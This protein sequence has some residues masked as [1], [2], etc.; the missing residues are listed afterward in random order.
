VAS[1]VASQPAHVQPRASVPIYEHLLP[2]ASTPPDEHGKSIVPPKLTANALKVAGDE[3]RTAMIECKNKRLS[4][5]LKTYVASAECSNPRIVAAY[6]RAGYRYMDLMYLFTANR[7]ESLEQIDN[8]QL[9]E[10]QAQ[11][12]LA[13]LM[14]RIVDEERRRDKGQR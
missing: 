11:L 10:A 3:A 9:T 1:I 12:E 4:G 6:Q 8:G 14:T 2:Q 5:E 7:R 13:Q